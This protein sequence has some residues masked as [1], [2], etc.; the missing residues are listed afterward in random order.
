MA[1]TI[2]DGA[3]LTGAGMAASTVHSA[4]GRLLAILV[5]HAQATVQTVTIYDNTAASGTVIMKLS[6]DPA[7]CPYYVQF[8]RNAGIP[9]GTG[10][11]VVNGWCDMNIWSVDYG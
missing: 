4:A 1:K 11:H 6:V 3:H 8:P 9:F 10:L 2:K 7:R 5:S